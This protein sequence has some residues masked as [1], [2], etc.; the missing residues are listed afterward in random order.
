MTIRF[1]IEEEQGETFKYQNQLPKLPI[2]D[3]QATAARYLSA[4]K[5]L[6]VSKNDLCAFLFL[7]LLMLVIDTRGT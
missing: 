6:Q 4:L 2:P 1:P 3:L 7:F 5:P